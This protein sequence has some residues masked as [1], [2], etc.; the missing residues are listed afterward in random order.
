[1]TDPA[2]PT[3]PNHRAALE[4]RLRNICGALGVNELRT[5]TLAT[6]GRRL[7]AARR[8]APWPPTVQAWPGW[9]ER[10]TDA[11]EGLD[12]LPLAEA[13]AWLNDLIDTAEQAAADRSSSTTQVCQSTGPG[14]SGRGRPP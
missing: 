11:A 9:D 6:V 10:Y 3:P 2:Y 12:V 4:Q 7:F 8:V 14:I 13:V 5:R 1:M